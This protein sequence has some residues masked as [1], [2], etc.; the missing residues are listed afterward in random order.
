M[1]NYKI[2]EDIAAALSSYQLPVKLPF[3]LA[4][5]PIMY[6]VEYVDGEWG[7]GLLEANKPLLLQPSAKV[8]HYGQEIFEGMKAYRVNQP[9]ATLFRP[10]RNWARFNQSAQRMAMPKIPEELF[11]EGVNLVTAY[12]ETIIPEKSGESLYLRPFMFASETNLGVSGA[13]QFTYMVISSPSEAMHPGTMKVLIERDF[14]RAALGGT[15]GAKT[16]GNYASSFASRQHAQSMGFDQSLWLD[17]RDQKNIEELSVMNFFAVINGE[18]HTPRLTGSLLDGVTRD[19]ILS[20]AELMGVQIHQ[21]AINIDEL[22]AQIQSGE[23]SEVFCCGT[24]AIISPIST[25][26]EYDGTRY[27]L[28]KSNGDLSLRLR[29]SLLGIQE[30]RLEDSFGWLRTIPDAC[31]PS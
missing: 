1:S 31:Y 9:R 25:L 2:H 5:G 11:M 8:L 21:R 19:S 24:G 28:V 18:L 29:E 22:I 26:G 16:G 20:L 6:S 4:P 12:S 27:Q 10:E 23:C 17:P 30:S 15:G 14:T 3:G 13:N 7:D